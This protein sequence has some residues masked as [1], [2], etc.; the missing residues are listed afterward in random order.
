MKR[1][2]NDECRLRLLLQKCIHDA[3]AAGLP[4]VAANVTPNVKLNHRRDCIGL[5][6]RTVDDAGVE[7]FTILF[8]DFYLALDDDEIGNVLM[9]ELI[10]TLPDCWD[11][12]VSFRKWMALVNDHGYAVEI[13]NRGD[14][15]AKLRAVCEA[16]L[17]ADGP[18][19]VTVGCD[20]GCR[21][22]VS[23]RSRVARHPEYF[24]CNAHHDELK[25]IRRNK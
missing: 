22:N 15:A 10:H 25:L 11:H 6:R 4:V 24:E 19:W 8:S 7:R 16:A 23:C 18:R 20:H 14:R 17:L 13:A 12:G 21:I 9:H 3:H 1:K 2:R 5:C